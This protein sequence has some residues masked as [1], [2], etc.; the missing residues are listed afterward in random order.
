[1]IIFGVV[2][3][4]IREWKPDMAPQAIVMKR[5]GNSVPGITG[6]PPYTKGVNAGILSVGATMMIP[7]ASMATTPSFIIELR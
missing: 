5:Y 4:L 6:P 1:M 7:A 2:P 3:E